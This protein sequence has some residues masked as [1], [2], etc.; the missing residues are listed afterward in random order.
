MRDDEYEQ[1]IADPNDFMLNVLSLRKY[2]KFKASKEEAYDALKKA[3]QA[4]K[5]H[6]EMN[7][8]I[9]NK[10]RDEFGII[11]LWSD[12]FVQHPLDFIHDSLRGM[13]G[14]LVDIRR[15]P[16]KLMEAINVLCE[17]S[18]AE[19]VT[20][21]DIIKGN[22]WP[23]VRSCYHIAPYIG[24]KDYKKYWWPF[25]LKMWRPY[26]DAGIKVIL[27][28][29]GK[30]G[31]TFDMFRELPKSSMIIQLEEDDPFEVYKQIGDVAT[32][33]TGI[34]SNLL[35]YGTKQQCIDYVKKCFDT[36]APGG[37]FIFMSDRPLLCANDTNVENLFAVYEFAK[38]YG[39]Y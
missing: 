12:Y 20:D 14:A 21:F 24:L 33:A 35:K 1:L 5:T 26:I 23:F 37:G 25:F 16:D 36:F 38:E 6:I 18:L 17:K 8:L 3:A 29:E 22:D 11:R 30:S 2:D 19:S 31:Y 27:K 10:V 9:Q 13:K 15:H 32:L 34:T 28:S 4:M 7:T 39:K